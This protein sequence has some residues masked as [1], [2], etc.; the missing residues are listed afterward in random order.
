MITFNCELCGKEK[1]EPLA[2]YKK[3]KKHFCSRSCANK[4]R[5]NPDK[6][7]RKTYEKQY[8]N[9]PENKERRKMA[10]R[11]AVLKR[12]IVLGESYKKAMLKRAQHRA[13]SKRFD[14]NITID[15]I[16]IPEYCPVLG[17]KL[18]Y[19]LGSGGKDCSPSIDRI[20][21]SKGY[22]KGNI[23]IIS[24]KA[25]RIKTDATLDD[26]EKLYIFMKSNYEA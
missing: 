21:S 5:I 2:W 18:E 6:L 11:I 24:S 8:W 16:H 22:I 7:D 12:Y 19:S 4:S 9:K 14:F 25:N 23:Q 20:D 1:S 17:M 3:R 26:I 15:D 10:S 13:A